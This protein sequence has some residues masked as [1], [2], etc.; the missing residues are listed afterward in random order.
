MHSRLKDIL[1]YKQREV[2]KLKQ[3]GI[4]ISGS[5][6]V[7]SFRNFQKAISAPGKVSL[8]AEVKFASPSAGRIREAEDPIDI[9]RVYEQNG[10]AAIS[11]LTE[12]HFFKGEIGQLPLIKKAVG[13]PVLR[14]DFIIDQVQVAESVL[15]GADAI[16]LIVR[17]LS[18]EQL[19]SLFQMTK[20]LGLSALVEVHDEEELERALNCGAELIGIN[21][22]DLDTFE[23]NL[24]TT[25]ELAPLV[26]DHCTVV[27]ESGINNA[28]DVQRLIDAGV[29]AMLVGTAI[30]KAEDVATKVRELVSA[31]GRNNGKG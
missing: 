20:D 5:R 13:V 23:V 26:P 24:N 3:N 2:E 22:R 31:G 7:P 25:M 16:L 19:N 18:D 29:D 8:I 27:S 1:A 4:R 14:K 9:A 21:N 15:Y 6:D 17:L 28:Q 10:A 11:H 30:M 12:R